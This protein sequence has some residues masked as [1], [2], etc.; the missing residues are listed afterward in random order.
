MNFGLD[1]IFATVLGLIGIV[2]TY[3]FFLMKHRQ[4]VR[5][6]DDVTIIVDGGYTPEVISID[7]GKTTTLTFLRKDFSGCLEDVILGD[8]KIRKHLPLNE[9]VSISI[10]PQHK[11]EFT[12]SCGMNMYHGRIIV[13]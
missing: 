8:F 1:K 2:F 12:Y 7:Q 11:G 6:V 13:R 9:S 5:V 3:W 10:T 4:E